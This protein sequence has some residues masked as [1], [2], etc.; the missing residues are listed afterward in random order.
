MESARELR[1]YYASKGFARRIGF[2]ERPAVVVIDYYKAFTDEKSP[3]GSNYKAQLQET[4]RIL[5]AARKAR[6][7]VFFTVAGFKP[8]SP[9]ANRL[10]MMKQP[11]MGE[12]FA[13]GSPWVEVDPILERQPDEPV[14]I[15]KYA[16]AFFGTDLLSRLNAARVDTVILTGCVTSGC[17]R[18]TAVDGISYEFRVIVVEEAVGDRSELS[19]QVSLADMDAKYADVVSLDSVLEYLASRVQE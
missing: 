18:A 14:I 11:P 1:E 10:W 12:F 7:P 17:V 5:T 16:S 4:H 8:D 9:D 3:Y 15:K 2:G 13:P 19:H 6:I